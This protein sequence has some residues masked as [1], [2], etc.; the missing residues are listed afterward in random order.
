MQIYY[1]FLNLQIKNEIFFIICKNNGDYSFEQSPLLY[2]DIK[3]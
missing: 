3:E 1:Y 2:G